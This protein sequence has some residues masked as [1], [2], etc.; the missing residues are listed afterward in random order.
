MSGTIPYSQIVKVTPG[1]LSAG[2][3]VDNLT[4]L[5]LTTNSA[6]TKM[7]AFSS[8]TAVAAVA[9]AGSVLANMAS[10]YFSGH[11][12][13][14]I[15]PGTL[16]V[17]P[18]TPDTGSGSP[19]LTA[20]LTTLRNQNNLWSGFTF[21]GLLT[22]SE[23]QEVAT[24]VGTQGDQIWAPLTDSAAI[25]S[26]GA[27]FGPWLQTQ[28]LDGVTA[29]YDNTTYTAALALAWMGC[30]NFSSTRGRQT[31]AFIEDITELV[32]PQVT[33]GNTA[34]ALTAAGYTF[35]GTYGNGFSSGPMMANGNVSGR[36]M[37]A[38][39]FVNQ[40]WLNGA[41]QLDL[42][43]TFKNYGNIP[44]N[45]EGDTIAE[46]SISETLSEFI[47]FGGA[48]IG[49]QLTP[50][51]TMEIN[52][53][54]GNNTAAQAVMTQGYYF[55]PNISTATG[56]NRQAR[57]APNAKLWYADGQS[58]QSININSVDVL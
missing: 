4:A 37:W 34:S 29:I 19:T 16:Y 38:D 20:Q 22:E 53:A 17:A 1:V 28:N 18:Y 40:I 39:S 26:S 10:I 21:D 55:Q 27:V 57:I 56:A 30:L 25:V 9:G 47:A 8:A 49:V 43:N 48:N 58:V 42:V 2:S 54:A 44:F 41:I 15:T 11:A 35:Y 45:V 7:Q 14:S 3:G 6:I 36:F 51:Q 33:D 13:A 12:T 24:W 50:A 31:L 5:I 46:A 52:L 32:T 23:L